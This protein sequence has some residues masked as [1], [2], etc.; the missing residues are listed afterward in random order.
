MA[1]VKKCPH[2]S[3]SCNLEKGQSFCSARCEAA[4]GTTELM[5]EC[6]HA[7]CKGEA[8]KA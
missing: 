8:L 2:P 6:G 4:K 5:C 1:D 3:C 7:G